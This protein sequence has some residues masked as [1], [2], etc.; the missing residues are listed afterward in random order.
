MRCLVEQ[1]FEKLLAILYHFIL[2][3]LLTISSLIEHNEWL[4]LKIKHSKYNI[5]LKLLLQTLSQLVSWAKQFNF[6]LCRKVYKG[7]GKQ[8]IKRQQ[9]L[10]KYGKICH[11]GNL[12]NFTTINRFLVSISF[13]ISSCLLS[14]DLVI[15][16][17]ASEE[18]ALGVHLPT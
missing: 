1:Q 5:Q 10:Y 11:V 2:I 15:F 6:L 9:M 7:E 16:S 14:Y 4:L 13:W 8:S 18:S 3:R 17:R 12:T